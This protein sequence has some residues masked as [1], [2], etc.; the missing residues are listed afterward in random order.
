[1]QLLCSC[2]FQRLTIRHLIE[3]GCLRTVLCTLCCAHL[4]DASQ[5]ACKHHMH[6]S[7]LALGVGSQLLPK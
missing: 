3:G 7:E 6:C 1:M 4:E 5:G 2:V